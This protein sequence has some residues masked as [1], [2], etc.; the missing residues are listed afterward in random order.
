MKRLLT[1]LILA[2]A[3]MGSALAVDD[4]S[5][6][7]AFD[8]TSATV[9]IADNIKS[10][11]TNNSSGSHVKLVQSDQVNET[12][13][14]ILY[15]LSGTSADGEFYLEG[16]YKASVILNALTL[17]NPSGPAINIQNGKRINVSVKNETEN[18]LTDGANGDWKGCFVCKGHTEFKG[19]GKLTVNGKSAN[20][21]WSKEYVEIKNCT[22]NIPSAVKD[23]LN[24]NQYFLMESGTLNIT[25][26]GDDG[27][28][29]SYKNDPPAG[30]EDTG[31]F[32]QKDG[33]ISISGAAFYCVKA[34]ADIQFNGG[35]QDFD[36]KNILPN[37][38]STG[39]SNVKA[40]GIGEADGVY[41]LNGRRV[42]ETGNRK[43]IYIIKRKDKTTKVIR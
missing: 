36:T 43:G 30:E 24:C 28:Q 20:G 15:Y 42:T 4:N 13:G 7:I 16:S 17:T 33:T 21:I 35:T 2:V 3:G 34:D 1:T 23:G 11:I 41:D 39:I 22:I 26:P 32:T 29:V 10:Y 37:A 12:V 14:E 6:E 8:G 38:A 27:I 19:K 5:V 31:I 18:S 40:E 9:T 25:N